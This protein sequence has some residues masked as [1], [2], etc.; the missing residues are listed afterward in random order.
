PQPG[1][2]YDPSAR[3]RT[4]GQGYVSA[5]RPGFEVRGYQVGWKKWRFRFGM[6]P[7]VGLVLYTVEH[8]DGGRYR[9]I[10]YRASL[11]EM[12]V[13][14]GDPGWRI[15]NPLD[16]GEF[17]LGVYGRSSM[18]KGGEAPNNAVFFS[19]VVPNERGEPLEVPRAIALYERDGGVLWRHG[20]QVQRAEDL[21]LSFYTQIDNYDYGFNWVFHQDGVLEM[22][23]L[24]TGAVLWKAVSRS[25]DSSV[26]DN[27]N[28][29]GRLVGR[30]I[31]APIHQHFFS[32]RLDFDV[33]GPMNSVLELNTVVKKGDAAS[34]GVPSVAVRQTLFEREQQAQRRINL[35][36]QRSWK[37]INP[38]ARNRLGQPTAYVLAAGENALP[39]APPNSYLRRKAG[40][41]NRHVWV[42]PYDESEIY[43]AG[44]Y[45]NLGPLGEGLP[46]WTQANRKIANR[47]LVLWYTLGVTHMPRPE[48][49][50]VMPVSR[51]GFKLMPSG[52]FSRNPGLSPN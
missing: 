24:L 29:H 16:A 44:E 37:T 30:H 32:F 14:Y 35:A 19:S 4:H 43:A 50:P 47:D 3:P 1:E 39:I 45:V 10:L 40:F 49:W 36:T 17:G 21:V 9:S 22:E 34:S 23:A 2:L 33:D 31:E 48:E 25:S 26:A 7:R 27:E 20:N 41:V 8:E 51:T 46:T 15:W 5:A 13:P 6:H 38:T 42:T 18:T 12:V 11:S 52:F 28:T